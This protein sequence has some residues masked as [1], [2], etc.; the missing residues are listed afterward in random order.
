MTR[1][2]TLAYWLGT[3]LGLAVV[4][5]G[6]AYAALA[7]AVAVAPFRGVAFDPGRWQA[8]WHCGGESDPDCALRRAACPRGPMV[9]DLI[10]RHLSP[11]GLDRDGVRALLGA[12]D[13]RGPQI[14]RGT[15][16]A[17]CDQVMLG[18][19]GGFGVDWDSL[20]I[21]YAPGGRVAA[22]GHVRR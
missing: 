22:A 6:G 12:P 2:W 10:D 1:I 9:A 21:C 16:H 17:D 19:C 20:L 11:G 4:L 15:R 3:A 18:M 7:Y 8:V 5:A 14:L 13:A